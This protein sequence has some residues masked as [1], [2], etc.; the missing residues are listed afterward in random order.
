M[1]INPK[2]VGTG[3]IKLEGT[4][5]ANVNDIINLDLVDFGIVVTVVIATGVI[6]PTMT[7]FR[8][9]TQDS[10]PTDDVDTITMTTQC[11]LMLVNS[12]SSARD[13]T[14]KDA[15]DNLSMVGDFTM[16]N[17][18]DTLSFFGNGAGNK[19]FE[20]ARADNTA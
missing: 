13:P 3:N 16:T 18:Q 9:D 8:V 6:A 14:F 5:N 4:I 2:E 17:P 1:V 19:M 10:D 15:T 7:H 12:T 20:I 11:P